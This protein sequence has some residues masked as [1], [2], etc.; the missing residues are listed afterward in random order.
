MERNSHFRKALYLLIICTLAYTVNTTL[1]FITVLHSSPAFALLSVGIGMLVGTLVL[2]LFFKKV[3]ILDAFSKIGLPSIISGG[4]LAIVGFFLYFGYA[5]FGLARIYPLTA[6]SS[7]LFLAIDLVAYRKKL[8]KKE[9]YGLILGVMVVFF[10]T[11]LAQSKGFSFDVT[12]IP[13]VLGIIF[14]NGVGYYAS[15]Y[16]TEK[17]STSSKLLIMSLFLIV[18]GI[19]FNPSCSGCTGN[20]Y[21]PLLAGLGSGFFLALAIGSE[22]SAVRIADIVKTRANVIFR[23]FVNNFPAADVIL[24]LIV[25]VALGSYT[26]ESLLGGVLI[27]VGVILLDRI[28]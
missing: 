9:V 4:S 24:I 11:F 14:F 8:S 12:T 18:L 5:S 21:I 15:M 1:S 22:V 23:N 28:R 6:A 10:G 27:A 17:Y 2:Y 19:I 7:I 16:K 25:S 26:V 20:F 3:M 13:F